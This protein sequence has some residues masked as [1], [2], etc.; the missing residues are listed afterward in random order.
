MSATSDPANKQVGGVPRNIAGAGLTYYPIPKA[1]ITTTLRYVGSSWMNTRNTLYVPSYTI[2]GLR[3]NY[4]ISSNVVMFAS[5]VNLFNRQF[6]TFGT[7]ST[8]VDY[9]QGT[10]QSINLGAKITF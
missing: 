2:V 4:E 8:S 10:P 5:I 7:G 1:S 3:A 6:I 9:T